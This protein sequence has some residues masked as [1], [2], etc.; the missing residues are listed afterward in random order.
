MSGSWRHRYVAMT[1]MFVEATVVGGSMAM[2]EGDMADGGGG[3][4][5]ATGEIRA[6]QDAQFSATQGGCVCG[7]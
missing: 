2:E 7:K 4:S 1:P 3:D 5:L 6:T